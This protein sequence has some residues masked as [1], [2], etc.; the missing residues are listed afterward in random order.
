M[1]NQCVSCNLQQCTVYDLNHW[2]YSRQTQVKIFDDSDWLNDHL[3]LKTRLESDVLEGAWRNSSHYAS[4]LYLT[5]VF[6]PMTLVKLL[7]KILLMILDYFP[8]FP[9]QIEYKTKILIKTLNKAESSKIVDMSYLL[10]QLHIK[11]LID[12]IAVYIR[13]KK[14]I[15]SIYY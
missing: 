8:H 2:H 15:L 10:E 7:A 11:C 14:V 1:Y 6:V 12:H 9:E 13:N 3:G 5:R 4:W